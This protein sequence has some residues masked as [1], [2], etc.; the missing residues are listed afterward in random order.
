MK[1]TRAEK[2]LY[3]AIY[4]TELLIDL[5]H[6]TGTFPGQDDPRH[7]WKRESPLGPEWL[8]TRSGGMAGDLER[9]MDVFGKALVLPQVALRNDH[10]WRSA[11]GLASADVF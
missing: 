3:E 11:V 9:V 4:S 2:S 7:E 8:T 10:C 5:F 1:I 6:E